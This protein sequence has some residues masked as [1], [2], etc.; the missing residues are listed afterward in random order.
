MKEVTLQVADLMDPRFLYASDRVRSIWL[1]LLA[2]CAQKE[3][4]GRIEKGVEVLRL[5]NASPEATALYT[6]DN[7]TLVVWGYPS[8]QEEI[9]QAKRA[10]GK[11]SGASRV[12][13]SKSVR[14]VFEDSA[15]SVTKRVNGVHKVE[16]TDAEWMAELKTKEAYSH[17]NL[18][19]EYQKCADWCRL[20][21]KEMSRRRF[22]N[23]ISRIS[24]PM[25]YDSDGLNGALMR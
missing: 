22:F 25:D 2:Y 12:N 9:I 8:K 20:N 3:N 10:G 13:N 23:W 15:K 16:Q 1:L 17:I 19:H 6:W 24:R 5:Y 14:R 18:D 7:T 11:R 4:G 21:R